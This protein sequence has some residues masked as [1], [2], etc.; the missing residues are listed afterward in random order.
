MFK[1][2]GKGSRG[3]DERGIF[4]LKNETY[5]LDSNYAGVT[6]LDILSGIRDGWRFT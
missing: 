2:Q 3:M 4:G 6:R 1:K 5:H